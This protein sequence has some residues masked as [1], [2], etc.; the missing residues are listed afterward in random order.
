MPFFFQL[1]KPIEIGTTI[2]IRMNFSLGLMTEGKMIFNLLYAT[3]HENK[4][5]S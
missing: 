3:P 2:K 4:Q 1:P 5:N